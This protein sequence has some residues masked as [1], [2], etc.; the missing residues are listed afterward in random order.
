MEEVCPPAVYMCVYSQGLLLE[1][2][3]T[4]PVR[5]IVGCLSDGLMFCGKSGLVIIRKV[6]GNTS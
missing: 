4:G 2:S 3:D 1:T 5:G 6:P